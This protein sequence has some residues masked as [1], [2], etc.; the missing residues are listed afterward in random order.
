MTTLGQKVFIE[1]RD[2]SLALGGDLLLR[3]VD[4]AVGRGEVLAIMGPSGQGK[5][6]LLKVI[7]GLLEPTRGSVHIEGND[8]RAMTERQRQELGRRTGMLF[9]KNALFDSLTALE[10][11]NFPQV[12]TLGQSEETANPVSRK[13][14]GAVGLAEAAD[15]YPAEISGGMQKR[16]GIARALALAPELILY[17]DPTAGLDPITSRTIIKLIKDLQTERKS[18][19]VV[20][21]NE[22]ARAFQIADRVGFVFRGEVVIAGT[23]EQTKQHK[24][25]RIHH[26]IRGQTAEAVT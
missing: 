6:I 8:R 1:L 14:L 11:V 16:L 21:T 3:N 2:V 19:V 15:R 23:P 4:L 12:E 13:L 25:P 22:V 24:D 18:T 9:Q 20:V 7:A 17:D 26:F 5:S 10:N